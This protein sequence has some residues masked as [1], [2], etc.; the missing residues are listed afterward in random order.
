MNDIE[1]KL[2]IVT[3][4]SESHIQWLLSGLESSVSV[5][6]IHI[7]DSGSANT[8]YLENL[9]SKHQITIDKRDNIGFVQGNNSA[10]NDIELYKWVLFINP[11]A[12][13][14]GE[15][16]DKLL[17]FCNNVPEK[18]SGVFTV[19]LRRFDIG[20]KIQTGYYDSKGITC[21]WYGKWFDISSGEKITSHHNEPEFCE[22]EAVCGAFMLLRS[23]L[24]INYLDKKGVEDSK[25]LI[26][27]IKRI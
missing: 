8:E 24:L 1:C 20:K 5:L 15:D 17:C 22:V 9:N 6:K 2:I 11:D 10:L 21:N 23:S 18:Q 4:N 7:V 12:R 3:H 19:P 25:T 13:I 14:E 26:I 16:L 27:C